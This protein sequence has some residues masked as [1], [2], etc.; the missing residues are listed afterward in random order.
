[1]VTMDLLLLCLSARSGAVRAVS[2]AAG[3]HA[4]R[5]DDC[6]WRVAAAGRRPG[7]PVLEGPAGSRRRPANTLPQLR[8]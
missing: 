5:A 7:L 1:M 6:S 3:D 2:E 4:G 8:V